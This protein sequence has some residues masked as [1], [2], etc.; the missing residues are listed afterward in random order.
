MAPPARATRA[1]TQPVAPQRASTQNVGAAPTRAGSVA[2][3]PPA[4]T[5]NDRQLEA[6]AA[7]DE[8]AALLPA[9]TFVNHLHMLM[10]AAL[11]HDAQHSVAQNAALGLCK[12]VAA[13]SP[14]FTVQFVAG[15]VFLD[16]QLVPLDFN[17]FERGL[18][19]T[20]ALNRLNAHELSFDT[21]L[22][23]G[24]AQR[25]AQALAAGSRGPTEDLKGV[26]LAGLTWREIPHAQSGIDA[27]G[28]DPEVAAIA[29]TVLGLSVVEQIAEEKEG[30]WPWTKGLA[31]VR[32]LEKG[33]A[34]KDGAAMR[35]VELAPDGWPLP[36][37]ALA[38]CQLVL[39]VLTRVG[40]S[41]SNRRAAAH[42][43]LALA[44]QGLGE[45]DGIDPAH[46]AD[47]LVA[48]MT[49]ETVQARSG[50][51]PQC[52]LV[53]T[54]VHMMGTSM[55]GQES[56]ASLTVTELIG[57]AYEMERARCPSGVAFDLTRADLLAHAV[58]LEGTR[59]SPEWVRAVIK[60]CG[61]V[62]VGA[63]VRL[64]DGRFGVVIEPGPAWNPWCPV[65][66]IGRDRVATKAPVMLIPPNK[67]QRS[68]S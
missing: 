59:F 37:R 12:A 51:A 44:L 33:L 3:T 39:Q 13:M 10:K 68:K 27:E 43:A 57:L 34:A 5:L 4:T 36:R 2:V 21:P 19:L 48:R 50:I 61:A 31:V 1:N 6:E 14:P 49:R 29:H 54:L 58:Q 18:Q 28:V 16:R 17:H 24:V 23:V 35:V 8:S 7:A 45:R 42:A 22:D 67:L 62:P 41:P 38:A 64:Q 52:L 32:R 40:A 9:W 53:T 30:P 66:L 60:I 26:E 15:G 65:V 56:I 63:T 46:A 20:I 55:R 11:L 47:A 25:L